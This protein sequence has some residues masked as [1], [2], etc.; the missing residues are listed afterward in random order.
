MS[1]SK[2]WLSFGGMLVGQA[3]GGFI[4]LAI[5]ATVSYYC[6]QDE[7]KQHGL[8]NDRTRPTAAKTSLSIV[9][10][11]FGTDLVS[12]TITWMQ[13][14]I[15]T[16]Y[17]VPDSEVDDVQIV[18][19]NMV[20]DFGGYYFGNYIHNGMTINTFT[21]WDTL[22]FYDF[23]CHEAAYSYAEINKYD[24]YPV[25]IIPNLTQSSNYTNVN[26]PGNKHS[27][28]YYR[29]LF[30]PPISNIWANSVFNK[31][32]VEDWALTRSRWSGVPQIKAELTGEHSANTTFAFDTTDNPYN[33]TS[34]KSYSHYPFSFPDSNDHYLY[35]IFQPVA[36]SSDPWL[37]VYCDIRRLNIYTYTYDR[38]DT[39]ENYYN[40]ITRGF[41]NSNFVSRQ[42]GDKLFISMGRN[43][44]NGGTD[45]HHANYSL[46]YD[47]FY[48]DRSDYT[49]HSVAYN[50]QCKTSGYYPGSCPSIHIESMEITDDDILLIGKEVDTRLIWSDT[51][52]A[53]DNPLNTQQKIYMDLSAYPVG[54]WN[55]CWIRNITRFD[56]ENYNVSK[57]V[58][59][60]IEQTKEYIL[61]DF[62]FGHSYRTQPL[63]GYTGISEFRLAHNRTDQSEY[64]YIR[65]GSTRS[66]LI[67]STQPMNESIIDESTIIP[68]YHFDYEKYYGIVWLFDTTSVTIN[69]G[70]T[71]RGSFIIYLNSVLSRDPIPG[72]KI[73]F[74]F[75][76]H[77]VTIHGD[78]DQIDPVETYF[79][80]NYNYLFENNLEGLLYSP[81]R[82]SQV[83]SREGEVGAL[84][85]LRIDKVT[86]EFK[87]KI[88]LADHLLPNWAWGGALIEWT[89][90]S[91]TIQISSASTESQIMISF[92]YAQ[93]MYVA[94]YTCVLNKSNGLLLQVNHSRND[95]AEKTRQYACG[96]ICRGTVKVHTTVG[97]I[98]VGLFYNNY[99]GYEGIYLLGLGTTGL[100]PYL[101]NGDLEGQSLFCRSSL[102]GGP[103]VTPQC[104]SYYS[105]RYESPSIRKCDYDDKCFIS[106]GRGNFYYDELW[107][108]YPPSSLN[109][110]GYFNLLGNGWS[111]YGSIR[112]SK[113][114]GY[115]ILLS[116]CLYLTAALHISNGAFSGAYSNFCE[117]TPIFTLRRLLYDNVEMANIPTFSKFNIGSDNFFVGNENAIAESAC[118]ELVEDEIIYNNK[119]MTIKEPRFLYSR[120]I[121][122]MTRV[123]DIVQDILNSCQG[124]LRGNCYS[125]DTDFGIRG[126]SHLTIK[127]PVNN[128]IPSYY[129]GY[130]SNNFITS[131]GSD[132]LKK[133]YADF[134]AYP[135]D[136][137]IGDLGLIT[138]SGQEIEFI[139]LDQTST[140]ILIFE[141]LPIYAVNDI[142]FSIKKDSMKE[143]S[144]VYQRKSY[145]EKAN[146]VKIDFDNRL[147][148][149]IT[150]SAEIEDQYRIDMVDHQ[151]RERYY[152]IRGIKRATQAARMAVRLLD[153]ENYVNWNCGFETDIMGYILCIGDL[154]GITHPITNWFAK[155]FR[156]MT[157]EEQENGEVKLELEE[158]LPWVYHDISSGAVP[159]QGSGFG[160]SQS[161]TNYT[162][163]IGSVR[164]PFAYE[165]SDN[166]KVYVSFN[167][168][169]NPG[170]FFAGITIHARIK[171]ITEWQLMGNSVSPSS[172]V[173]ISESII[174]GQSTIHY[175]PDSMKGTFPTSGYLWIGNYVI[176]YSGL[177][178]VNNQ[179]VNIIWNEQY[180]EDP[181]YNDTTNVPSS[182]AANTL[183]VLIDRDNI[184]SFIPEDNWVGE[185][186]EIKISSVDLLGAFSVDTLSP[187][188]ELNIVGY[189]VKP[190]P[191]ALVRKSSTT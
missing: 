71:T 126:Q 190:Y 8:Y 34:S 135:D 75:S 32:T 18:I 129:F 57:E 47:L 138:I 179:F 76:S 120:T 142:S 187:I 38:F 104:I 7:S 50:Q 122:K 44:D 107:T 162:S 160:S 100:F 23:L 121:D 183:M 72:E 153:Y 65:E 66:V 131:Q 105:T 150:D 156:V 58:R 89:A 146:R 130:D 139:V 22:N 159:Y 133:I 70:L 79:L 63:P 25:T 174:F 115:D 165:D 88:T 46:E 169:D 33:P 39:V 84:V 157:M 77:Q 143:E 184:F 166:G 16:S 180:R 48:I 5:C 62:P 149:Y 125:S 189:K 36:G 116:S 24:P 82:Y 11:V 14:F 28:I 144:F 40:N 37:N 119:K 55:N 178:E 94:N 27:M 102:F 61:I 21:L 56:M 53:E 134:S 154:I 80:D 26:I 85:I 103:M 191:V 113:Q 148:G 137:W 87:G 95:P 2:E 73:F 136:Y 17:G 117:E 167:S 181:F 9:P 6:R 141:D 176:R 97:N 35:G 60:I 96:L 86:G 106:I 101:G 158:Y 164:N 111:N 42:D 31:G 68:P 171:G 3:V 188:I 177:D 81:I 98:W 1:S 155:P 49:L 140:Y 64:V 10:A 132:D 168:P 110:Y 74:G 172:S 147:M 43:W 185:T 4:G 112:M 170:S 83:Y 175:D 173:L 54:F 93:Y 30:V 123:M 92:H 20:L 45:H 13:P 127:I 128:E 109:P 99:P 69:W 59:R 182:F 12:A 67:V 163:P 124:I 41:N 145:L 15:T 186:I 90:W 51:R 161:P 118:S 78:E 91:G 152:E 108:W 19:A 29:G 52:V 114:G 151:I